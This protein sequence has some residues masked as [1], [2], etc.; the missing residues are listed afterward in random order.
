[1]KLAVCR[2]N[3][4]KGH[5]VGRELL[6]MLYREETGCSLPEI[7]IEERGKPYFA[8]S[9]LH[10]SISHTRT[11][12]V[13]VLAHCPVG[14]DAE[15]LDRQ[16]R[17]NIVRRALSESEYRQYEQS[18]SSQETFLRFWVLKEAA[19]KLSGEGLQGFPNH[20]Q[21]VLP[22]ERIRVWDGCL[23]AL[24]AEDESEGVE[25]YAV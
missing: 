6:A 15:E 19:V 17:G 24:M 20:T 22:D 12:A 13:C 8:D 4:R 7:R 5:E 1:M 25:F 3:G 21:F 16:L 18:E 14:V 23:I 10:F 11:H 9:P 2:L